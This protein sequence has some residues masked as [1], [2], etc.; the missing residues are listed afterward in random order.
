MAV[1]RKDKL[2][3][4]LT[5][6]VCHFCACLHLITSPCFSGSHVHSEVHSRP[7]VERADRLHRDVSSAVSEIEDP[8]MNVGGG[9]DFLR[10]SP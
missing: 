5:Q 1:M 2:L 10:I 7:G 9:S 6:P 8:G 3:N 4:M